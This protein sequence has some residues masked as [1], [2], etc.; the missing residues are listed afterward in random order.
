MAIDIALILKKEMPGI[1]FC[2]KAKRLQAFIVIS[3]RAEKLADYDTEL[4]IEALTILGY[5]SNA[6][7]KATAMAAKNISR[8]SFTMEY[9]I[10]RDGAVTAEGETVLVCFDYQKR[11]LRRFNAQFREKIETFESRR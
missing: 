5:I 6:Y 8:L 9:C 10:E 1:G 2:N 4:A 7:H 11:K 3:N